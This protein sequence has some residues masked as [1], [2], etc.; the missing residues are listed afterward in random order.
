MKRV[1][2]ELERRDRRDRVERVLLQIPPDHPWARVVV[3]IIE[4]M[5]EDTQSMLL[6][7]PAV[8]TSEDRVYNAGR[9]AF[10]EDLLAR[11]TT[12]H[13]AAQLADERRKAESA[14]PTA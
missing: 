6:A 11:L 7:P 5:A 10:A 13:R 2:T 8:C 1:L 4:D 3:E 9:V 12:W 14:A